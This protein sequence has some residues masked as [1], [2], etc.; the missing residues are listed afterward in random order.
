MRNN[1][2][3]PWTSGTGMGGRH[4]E[5]S[6]RAAVPG[7]S[8][9]RR[10]LLD[11]SRGQTLRFP[12]GQPNDPRRPIADH[13]Q[14]NHGARHLNRRSRAAGR[15]WAAAANPERRGSLCRFT[16]RRERNVRRPGQDAGREPAAAITN[17]RRRRARPKRNNRSSSSAYSYRHTP[18][19]RSPRRGTSPVPM[20]TMLRRVSEAQT[21][22]RGCGCASESGRTFMVTT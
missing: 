13:A 18:V 10:L 14:E 5:A 20:A 19:T 16:R 17:Q 4:R 2:S 15:G 6:R 11:P 22:P 8:R 21:H 12:R 7:G 9:A 3:S 1:V